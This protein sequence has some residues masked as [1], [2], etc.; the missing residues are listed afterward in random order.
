MCYV[1]ILKKIEKNLKLVTTHQRIMIKKDREF[2]IALKSL[3]KMRIVQSNRNNQSYFEM[4]IRA[5]ST[6]FEL[7]NPFFTH[8]LS[9]DFQNQ[10]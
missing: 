7:Q 10:L 2:L 5:Y 9:L 6:R 8:F 1:E 4:Q 3:K